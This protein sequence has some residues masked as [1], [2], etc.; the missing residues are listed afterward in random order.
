MRRRCPGTADDVGHGAR[1]IVN[2]S[3]EPLHVV[4]IGAG[5]GGYPAA[6]RAASLGLRVTLIDP[7]ECPGGV[8]AHR[9]CIPSKALLHM[10]SVLRSAG[11][12]NVMGLQFD[13]PRIDLGKMRAWMDEI[14]LQQ[15]RGLALLTRARRVAYTR[16]HAR[17]L[18]E[19]VL[20]VD[21][22]DAKSISFDAAIIATGSSCVIPA[23]FPSKSARIMDSTAAL[24]LPD[25]PKSMLV[26]G[27]GYI[28]LELGTVYAALGSQV[29]IAE[30]TTGL[31][32]G[33]DRDLVRP[34]TARIEKACAEVLLH[35]QVLELRPSERH[36]TAVLDLPEDGRAT[37]TFER[38]L[39]AVGRKP[40][41]EGLGLEGVCVDIDSHGFVCTDAQGRTSNPKIFA[42]GDVTGEPMLA[43][44]ATHEGHVAAEAIAGRPTVFEAQAI[45][46][47]VFTD[48][49]IAWC[50][51]T[52][53]DA[54]D[55][56]IDVEVIR[57]PWLASGRA[58]ITGSGDGLTKLII[59]SRS[60][61]MLGAGIVGLGAGDI[62]SEC[63]HAIEMAAT[64]DDM[65][66]T[67][68][69]HPTL[70]ETVMEG[71]ALLHDR[72]PHYKARR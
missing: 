61:R 55:R 57:Y 59:E 17:F 60:G 67:I 38:V 27:G 53:S 39:V 40:N 62:I 8:C 36:V 9:G 41:S 48:P 33:V 29:T 49:E 66:R 13:Q 25:V 2:E 51:M 42:V 11:S 31:L 56:G 50:G 5:P 26:V 54:K 19:R 22:G 45:P 28:G 46:A 21:G 68:H 35:T 23:Y 20:E 15:T 72:S 44:K 18:G 47:V 1:G 63:V 3:R 70:S 65:E 4:V 16:G 30:A 7:E 69:P 71:A 10:A 24:N 52:E 58:G 6:F 34:L 12:A 64:A 43:H 14:V 32:P 37:R